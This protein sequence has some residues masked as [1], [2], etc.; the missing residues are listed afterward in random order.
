MSAVMSSWG[1]RPGT[2]PL[3]WIPYGPHSTARVSTMFLTPGLG[4]RRVGEARSARPGV[5]RP[6]VDDRRR[7]A[8]GQVAAGELAGAEERAV[9]GDVDDGPPGVGAHVLGGDREV[10][11][12]VVDQHRRS[13]QLGLDRVERGG[14]RVGLPDVAGGGEHRAAE[15]ADLGRRRRRGARACGWR[16][17]P[18]APSRANSTAMALPSPVPPP[19]TSTVVPSKVPGG[20]AD[21]PAGG[22]SGSP[23]VCSS[24]RGRQPRR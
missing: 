13:A 12:R 15:G 24:G 20:R 3:T 19:V 23:M 8:G 2:R 1:N 6:D 16:S 4:R 22:G 10:G 5:R 7:S 21:A 14:D 17:R 9:E 18:T 11:G